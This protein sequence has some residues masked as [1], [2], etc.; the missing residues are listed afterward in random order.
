MFQKQKII[1]SLKWKKIF[2]EFGNKE[3]ILPLDNFDDVKE[4]NFHEKKRVI[5]NDLLKEPYLF[6]SYQND[7]KIKRLNEQLV[8]DKTQE[9]QESII[10]LRK[11]IKNRM[12][13]NRQLIKEKTL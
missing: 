1:Y 12:A 13:K 9:Q 3:G 7:M 4:Q 5:Y 8:N 11:E 6:R 10:V 2:C